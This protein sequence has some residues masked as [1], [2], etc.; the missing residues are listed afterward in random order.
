MANK[1]IAKDSIFPTKDGQCVLNLTGPRDLVQSCIGYAPPEDTLKLTA[2]GGEYVQAS[3]ASQGALEVSGG[4]KPSMQL[5]HYGTNPYNN[6]R[7]E[8]KVAGNNVP[9]MSL[10]R[11]NAANAMSDL[12]ADLAHGHSKL[13][14]Q[15][16]NDIN[17]NFHSHNDV[18][19]FKNI[20]EGTH[21]AGGHFQAMYSWAVS[22]KDPT[23]FN[24]KAV[25]SFFKDLDA[26]GIHA[27]S[28]GLKDPSGV[29]SPMLA[30]LVTKEMK[31]AYPNQA[32]GIHT[33]DQAGMGV[34]S[35]VAAADA[36]ANF[37]DVS[38]S[39]A[40]VKAQ[41]SSTAVFTA[42]SEAG[43]DLG[44]KGNPEGHKKA[45]QALAKESDAAAAMALKYQAMP[46]AQQEAA[47]AK[48]VGV[49]NE[50]KQ[51]MHLHAIQEAASDVINNALMQTLQTDAQVSAKHDQL[52]GK[53]MQAANATANYGKDEEKETKASAVIQF[54]NE[55]V[56]N[57]YCTDIE[58][59]KHGMAGG[60]ST[61]A[62]NELKKFGILDKLPEL[63]NTM[64]SVREAAGM[65]VLV[66]PFADRVLRESIRIVV[67]KGNPN[68]NFYDDYAKELTG[69]A[70][71]VQGVIDPAKQ[72]QA[73][74]ERTEKSLKKMVSAD[75]FERLTAQ[76]G[77]VDALLDNM[78]D[79]AAPTLTADR[80]KTVTTRAQE[81]QD[82]VKDAKTDKDYARYLSGLNDQIARSGMK[83]YSG[84][85]AK[86][87]QDVIGSLQAE[88][89]ALKEKAAS[90]KKP[91]SR[92]NY[93]SMQKGMMTDT[94]LAR[95]MK[96]VSAFADAGLTKEQQATLMDCAAVT[97]VVASERLE[98][99][100]AKATA[101][102]A[103][104]YKANNIPLPVSA[105][106]REEIAMLFGMYGEKE[107]SAHL[108]GSQSVSA[109]KAQQPDKPAPFVMA[110][111]KDM[112]PKPAADKVQAAVVD[113]LASVQGADR[114]AVSVTQERDYLKIALLPSD[115][116]HTKFAPTITAAVKSLG[117]TVPT[118]QRWMDKVEDPTTSWMRSGPRGIA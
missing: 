117:G 58:V 32:F 92:G 102:S 31:K 61:L 7:D 45:L 35:C 116:D 74:R 84:E 29:L 13:M 85:T 8:R 14:I 39:T 68:K 95:G 73:L 81:L 2:A 94:L 48:V 86:D 25:V 65:T 23:I 78:R 22:D 70:G 53:F 3:N 82:I 87:V 54:V 46:Y 69:E 36:G 57:N 59:R 12:P 71:P 51:R 88:A 55:V 62:Y 24:P 50:A 42:L 37:V 89:K 26:A 83:T 98:P 106:K 93:E 66:T 75:V 17:R 100:L 104:F 97:T 40:G 67:A 72:R 49:T 101:E 10:M 33:H 112:Y 107:V 77:A 18:R 109:L 52:L 16:G 113:A 38:P 90:I 108:H 60:Q 114:Y 111:F 28:R 91:L 110:Q 79:L 9:L 105:Q 63:K 41:P 118:S 64:E 19:Q 34:A 80:L 99:G 11:S 56:K 4:T 76:G 21:V 30:R 20:E 43:I 47:P 1:R 6:V 27:D 15:A 96:G 5:K 44:F 103:A 115:G